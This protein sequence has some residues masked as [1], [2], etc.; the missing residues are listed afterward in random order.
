MVASPQNVEGH[1]GRWAQV[2]EVG[3]WCDGLWKQHQIQGLLMKPLVGT[4]LL[5][6]PQEL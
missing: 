2:T 6:V 4:L 3:R 5:L 1:N